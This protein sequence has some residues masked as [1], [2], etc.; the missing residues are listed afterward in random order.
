MMRNKFI[1]VTLVLIGLIFGVFWALF[2]ITLP[3]ALPGYRAGLAA[4][5]VPFNPLTPERWL[6]S[7]R[8]IP[9]VFMALALLLIYA[10]WLSLRSSRYASAICLGA[11]AYAVISYVLLACFSSA[12]SGA[13]AD[14]V[15][16]LPLLTFLGVAAFLVRSPP[17]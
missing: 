10:G 16:Y 11:A 4:G 15:F 17:P 6:Q 14:L 9:I 7:Q 13:V 12:F 2:F 1:G 3:D 8:I 5:L